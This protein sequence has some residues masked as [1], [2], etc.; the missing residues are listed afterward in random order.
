MKKKVTIQVEFEQEFDTDWYPDWKGTEEDF[1][2][3]IIEDIRRPE[4]I[5]VMLEKKLEFKVKV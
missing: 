3:I 5:D 1:D 4:Y 2:R